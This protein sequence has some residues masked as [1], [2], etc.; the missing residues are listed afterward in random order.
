MIGQWVGHIRADDRRDDLARWQRGAIMHG[1][2]PD[3][4]V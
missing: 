4:V 1:H 2:N 3:Q